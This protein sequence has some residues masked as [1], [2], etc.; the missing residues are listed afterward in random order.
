MLKVCP[1]DW[2]FW[3][4]ESS[5]C[6]FMATNHQFSNIWVYIV[7]LQ[8]N[9]CINVQQN[10]D[11]TSSSSHMH[12]HLKIL[13]TRVYTYTHKYSGLTVFFSFMVSSFS[14]FIS[15]FWSFMKQKCQTL[16]GSSFSNERNRSLSLCFF[17]FF[18]SL[19]W[20]MTPNMTLP[21]SLSHRFYGE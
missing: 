19:V 5:L 8:Q 20:Q 4:H 12:V 15:C 2:I 21:M 13:Q 17:F 9:Y 6:W 14:W 10:I 18:V 3:L 7:W 1:P 16:S 11:S